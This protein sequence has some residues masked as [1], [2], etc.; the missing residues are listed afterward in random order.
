MR[1]RQ[2]MRVLAAGVAV[3]VMALSG[4]Q[5][6]SKKD[7]YYLI[8]NNLKLPYWK[9]VYQ[10]FSKAG[11]DYGVTA[12]LEG[13]DTFDIQG[14]L[15]ALK[16]VVASKPAGIL[17]SVS[18]AN[19]LHDEIGTA[20]EAGIP[21]ITVDSDA[22]TSARLFFIGTN[23]LQAGHLGALRLISKLH[24]KGNVVFYTIA[25]QP[26]LE[27]RLKGYK[28]ALS[29]HP[30][31]KIVDVFDTKGDSGTAF[32]QTEAYLGK[33]GA[34][35]IDAFVSLESTAGKSI[36]EVLK[37]KNVTDRTVIAMDVNSDTLDLI[38]DGSIDSTI[39]QK[40]YTMGY[41]G[42]K[43]LDEIH[44]NAPTKLRTNY[45]VDSFAPYPMFI[46]TGTAIVD[47]NN[48]DVYLGSAAAA[49]GK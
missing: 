11:M 31:I 22:P 19:M 33:T 2:G 35:K 38:K 47:K 6:H 10:G 15:T 20:I 16:K 34:D 14:E 17:I 30:G 45:G 12:L 42:L 4:C 43:A 49:E 36:A 9:T 48:V 26:N 29:T 27:E 7:T 32:D 37:R 21:V 39:S 28:D 18:D 5:Y 44:H 1:T 25:G 41:Y 24:D 13:P 3:G 8:S 40:P 46:D 23:N